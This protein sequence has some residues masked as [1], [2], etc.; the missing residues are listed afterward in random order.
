MDQRVVGSG[1]I[2][3]AEVLRV[4]A[5]T[6]RMDRARLN[7]LSS[8]SGNGTLGDR[9]TR[10]FED[11]AGAVAGTGTGVPAE[12][13][14]LAGQVLADPPLGYGRVARLFGQGFIQAGGLAA[15]AQ[16]LS[17]GDLAYVLPALQA[18][19]Q[20]DNPA[21]PG[22][23]SV[24]DALIPAALA[25]TTAVQQG[26]TYQQAFQG[27]VGAAQSGVRQ[28]ARL[29]QPYNRNPRTGAPPNGLPDP[30]AAAAQTLVSGLALSFLG[31]PL[32][33]AAPEQTSTNVLLNLLQQGF[34][35]GGALTVPPTPNPVETLLGTGP[36]RA[37]PTGR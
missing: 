29:A 25:F 13:L 5:A 35:L 11:A 23:G 7:G 30:G 1:V 27:M 21:Q 32:P 19:A 34:D 10:A 8:F 36:E 16:G 28:T 2:P 3:V 14:Q 37:R 4:I 22:E 18:G 15:G 6:F 17:L 31:A 24:L 12:D 9:L 20:Q 33:A 26:L